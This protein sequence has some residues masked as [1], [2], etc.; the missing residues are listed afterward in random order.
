MILEMNLLLYIFGE[1]ILL[2]R[3]TTGTIDLK[4]QAYQ[5]GIL[6]KS[7]EYG[8]LFGEMEMDGEKFKTKFTIRNFHKRV[9]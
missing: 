9:K 4:I 7:S 2:T 6:H 5:S 8:N 3:N 1:R